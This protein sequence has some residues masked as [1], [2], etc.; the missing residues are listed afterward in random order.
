MLR[1]RPLPRLLLLNAGIVTAVFAGQLVFRLACYDGQW[2]PNTYYAKTGGFSRQHPAWRYIYDGAVF[3][4][5]NFAGLVL[6]GAGLVWQRKKV[7]AAVFLPLGALAIGGCLLPFVTGTDWML[8]WR[9]VMPYL[10]LAA[11]FLA[12]GMALLFERAPGRWAW[13]GV[14]VVF[15]GLPGMWLLHREARQT[16]HQFTLQ[17]AHGY[18]TGHRALARWLRET[19]KPGDTVALMDI[20]IIGY[21]CIDQRILDITGLTDRYIARSPGEFLDKDYDLQYIL[22]QRPEYI[23]LVMHAPATGAKPSASGM[24]L[25]FWTRIEEKIY[26]HPDFMLNYLDFS[27]AAAA[28][29]PN[30]LPVKTG[31][32]RV[33]LHAHPD[34]MYYYL[35][36]FRYIPRGTDHK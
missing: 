22:K 8:G 7:M 19:A 21:Y 30:P 13:L 10:P 11:A 33:F 20:G 24:R 2:L 17:R 31:A 4:L 36:V 29:A 18:E 6:A 34:M 16:F 5:F 28:N 12:A 27:A 1:R 25:A 32:V 14:I 15:A 3:P 26:Q 35:A 9:L 23:V